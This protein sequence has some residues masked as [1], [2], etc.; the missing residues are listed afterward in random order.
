MDSLVT[1]ILENFKAAYGLKI[2][3]SSD[4]FLTEKNLLEFLMRLGR[5]T[6][7]AVFEQLDT[8]YEGAVIRKDARKYK[9]VGYRRTSLH[10]LF[11]MVEYRRAYYFS[12]QEGGGGYFP[13]D[14]KLGIQMRHTPGCQYFLSSFTGREAYQKS[15]DR[16]HEIFRPDAT[17]LISLRKSLDM[18]AELGER[19]EGLRQE[20]IAQVFDKRQLI[21]KENV[22]KERMAVS[23]DATKLRQRGE[24]ERSVDGK[25]TCPTV[26]RDVKVGAVSSIGWDE[27]QQEA[28][29]T[30]SSYVS[31][32]EHADEFFKRLTVEVQR[33]AEDVKKTRLVF[34]ADGAK[35]IWD[36]FVELAPPNS[37][38]ILDFYHACEHVSE[39]CKKLYGEQTPEYWKHFK[40]WKTTLWE[41]KVETF[42]QELHVIRDMVE[43]RDYR[44][45]IQG[46]I[47]YFTDNKER[48]QYDV[49][50][51]ARLPIGSGT[52]ESAC[53][54]VI[55]G[56]MKQGGMTWSETGADGMLQ[57]RSS[58]ASGR[59][60]QDFLATLDRA[61]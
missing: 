43:H 52:I 36:R 14:E 49:Y 32:I 35:W 29:C 25:R 11:G 16:F 39:L 17:E 33:R 61:A 55:A 44:D 3:D 2:T 20:E 41:G 34:L 51:G 53:K 59:H 6:M 5:A 30:A 19:L 37:T 47:D 54:N 50:R 12:K 24:E 22:I 38:F 57:I 58:I 18:D 26:W 60:L 42:L 10:G 9:F 4:M 28:F 15:L 13:Q 23:V 48:M 1:Q 31:G 40:A 21:A 56:R 7:G 45:L 46:Q 27:K 8:G